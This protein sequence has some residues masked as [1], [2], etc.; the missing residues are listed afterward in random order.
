MQ[1]EARRGGVSSRGGSKKFKP[2]PSSPYGAGLKFCP[3]LALPLL[4][5]KENPHE[6]KQRGAG[7]M[8]QGKIAIPICDLVLST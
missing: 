1:G 2:I 4:R 3:I 5:D 7:Q 6:A 8:R